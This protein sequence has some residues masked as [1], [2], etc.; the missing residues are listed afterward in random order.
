[1][2]AK[3]PYTSYKAYS[4]PRGN[5]PRDR[6][7]VIKRSGGR[8]MNHSGTKSE[9]NESTQQREYTRTSGQPMTSQHLA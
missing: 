1:M 4:V 6:Y 8:S 2:V 5:Q 7:G 3:E 9:P